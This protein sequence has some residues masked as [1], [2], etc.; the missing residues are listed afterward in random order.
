MMKKNSLLSNKIHAG[1]ILVLFNIVFHPCLSQTLP[2]IQLD[3]PDQT[4][5]PYITPKN[6]IQVENGLTVENNIG[7]SQTISHPTSLWKYG[8]NDKFELRLI[9]ELVTQKIDGNNTFG[10]QPITIGFKTT[11]FE[12]QGIL[13]KTSFIGHVTSSRLG[14]AVYHTPYIAPSFR[15][16]MQ[17]V[18]SDKFSL[19]YNL[20]AEWDGRNTNATYIYTFTGGLGLTEKLGCYAELYGFLPE[21]QTPDHRF[22]GGFTYLLHQDVMIDLSAGARFFQNIQTHYV[23]FGFSFR[24]NTRR[25]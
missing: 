6:Y 13:P 3:R 7:S 20:G 21:K 15:F 1:V 24:F 14:S 18:I 12:Q 25:R 22:D 2:S 11:L 16:T 17:H 9:T 8:V 23:S 4:E 10:L 19:S 5:C